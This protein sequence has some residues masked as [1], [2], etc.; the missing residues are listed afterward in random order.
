MR[1]RKALLRFIVVIQSIL[2]LTHF[3]LYKTWTFGQ[4]AP[5]RTEHLWLAAIL[6][7]LSISFVVASV[8]AFSHTNAPLRALY[9]GAAVWMGLLSF[10]FLAAVSAWIIFA[11]TALAGAHLNFTLSCR[12]CC[13]RCRHRFFRPFQRQLDSHHPHPSSPRESSR[14]LAR[15]QSRPRQ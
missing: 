15:T 9:R 4:A 5:S 13:G 6:G 1:H 14:R 3:F 12:C 7:V 10:L 11:V 8:L 2:F